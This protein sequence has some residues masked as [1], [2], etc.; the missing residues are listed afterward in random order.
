[1]ARRSSA[2]SA[3]LGLDEHHRMERFGIMF[4]AFV[5]IIG[6]LVAYSIKNHVDNQ[7]V[8]L[9]EQSKYTNNTIFSK[10]G[11]TVQVVDVYRNDACTKAFVLLK[12]QDMDELSMETSDY[13][14]YMTGYGGDKLTGSKPIAAIYVFG[15]QGYIGLYFSNPIGFDSQLYMVTLRNSN[16]M[17]PLDPNVTY[18]EWGDQS[19][20]VYNQCQ[21]IANFAGTAAP[22][23]DFLNKDSFTMT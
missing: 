18:G 15:L 14:M 16:P 4:C 11:E 9:T 20:S 13:K 21:L 1:M 6:L 10:T 12:V 3:R 23:V 19:F 5:I 7:H 22:V 8:A 2:L 17:V